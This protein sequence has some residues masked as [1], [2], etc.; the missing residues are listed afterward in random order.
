MSD[1][2][3]SPLNNLF[4][5]QQP[6]VKAKPDMARLLTCLAEE[7]HKRIAQLIQKWLNDSDKK[8][9]SR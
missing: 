1:Q 5:R 4:A 7:D 8:T 6:K 2:K 3:K 9:K